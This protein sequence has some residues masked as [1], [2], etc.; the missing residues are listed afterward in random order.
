MAHGPPAIHRTSPIPPP[1]QTDA[2]QE[3]LEYISHP[4][5]IPDF[6]DEITTLLVRHAQ[7]NDFSLALKYHH[8]VQ[9]ILKTAQ[10]LSLLFDAM[11]RTSPTEAFF[12]SRTYPDHTRELLLH[13]LIDVVMDSDI[14][15]VQIPGSQLALLPLDASE[16]AWF[17]EYLTRGEGRQ[18]ARAKDA[19]M[20]RK[21]SRGRYDEVKKMRGV[22][23]E[24][25]SVLA[26]MPG[27]RGV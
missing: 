8:T 24:W 2:V 6:A 17:D 20:A 11:A 10:A 26:M 4:S 27:A 12:F 5:L 23:K 21:I 3:A 13:Q 14:T 15:S 9:P 1:E 16:E 7:G 18:F 19:L 25:E 22:G